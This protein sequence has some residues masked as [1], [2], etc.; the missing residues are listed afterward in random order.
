MSQVVMISES[1]GGK[2]F[3]DKRFRYTGPADDK[4]TSFSLSLLCFPL[5]DD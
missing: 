2:P 4:N 3:S 5:K 1:R